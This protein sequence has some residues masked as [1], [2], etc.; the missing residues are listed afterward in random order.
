MSY[1]LRIP[2]LLNSAYK[3]LPD[4][5]VARFQKEY[6]GSLV[7]ISGALLF[8]SARVMSPSLA[9]EYAKVY[10]K[11]SV[12]FIVSSF[13]KSQ[14]EGRSGFDLL[15]IIGLAAWTTNNMMVWIQPSVNN[16][17]SNGVNH[18]GVMAA[19]DAHRQTV[20]QLDALMR[21]LDA[22]LM[23][24]GELKRSMQ[25][26]FSGLPEMI[27]NVLRRENASLIQ[28]PGMFTSRGQSTQE[29]SS[30]AEATP[31]SDDPDLCA[32]DSSTSDASSVIGP[33]T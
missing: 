17:A 2:S 32:E 14:I 6:A 19:S 29:I 13:S 7:L 12:E 4:L 31:A 23:N 26:A 11:S 3:G 30:E 15:I 20:A 28:G 10:S 24:M 8:G 21:L 1:L 16:Q 33:R 25:D 18:N 27:Q 5:G 9:F 22:G